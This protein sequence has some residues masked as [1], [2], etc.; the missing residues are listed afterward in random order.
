MAM[1]KMGFTG[2]VLSLWKDVPG[3]RVPSCDA[4]SFRI[5]CG[6]VDRSLV[7]ARRM[8]QELTHGAKESCWLGVAWWSWLKHAGLR[9]PTRVFGCKPSWGTHQ[10]IWTSSDYGLMLP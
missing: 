10:V 9:D 7:R 5:A 3:T 6:D 2:N 8:R 4:F 1:H